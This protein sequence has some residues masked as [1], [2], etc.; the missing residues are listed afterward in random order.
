MTK[1]T[2]HPVHALFLKYVK[3]VR[4][5]AEESA[6]EDIKMYMDGEQIFHWTD[7]SLSNYPE[8]L[9]WDRDTGQIFFEALRLGYDLAR[10]E[11]HGT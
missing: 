6:G 4:T 2:E 11:K 8:D 5:E 7:D 1:T 3:Y 10:K 9:T